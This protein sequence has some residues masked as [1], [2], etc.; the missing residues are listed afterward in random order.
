M[1]RGM[2]I[3]KVRRSKELDCRSFL[4]QFQIPL[5]CINEKNINVLHFVLYCVIIKL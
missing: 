3:A 1:S 4:F 2:R 5:Y